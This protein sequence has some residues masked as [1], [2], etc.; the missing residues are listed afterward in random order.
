MHP[1][2]AT[3]NAEAALA[4]EHSIYRH[5]QRLLKLRR[6]TPALVYGDYADLDPAH[7]QL[8]VYTRTLGATRL[9]TAINFSGDDQTLRLPDGLAARE[10]LLGNLPERVGVTHAT[11]LELGPLG[12]ADPAGLS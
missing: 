6:Q 11:E 3:I 9:L 1:D 5:Y 7:E 2:F 10:L 8:F 12:G 4:D